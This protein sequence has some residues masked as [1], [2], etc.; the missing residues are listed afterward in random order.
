M[1]FFILFRR[2][3]KVSK[4]TIKQK[5]FADE[6]IISGNATEAAIKAGYSEKYVNT[7]ASK[8]LQNTT[9]KSYINEKLAELESHK[10]ATADEVLQVFSSILREEATEE[11]QQINPLTGRIETLIQKPSIKDRIAA[12]KELMKRYPTAKEAERLE[13][14]IEKLKLQLMDDEEEATQQIGFTFN[15][16]EADAEC[17]DTN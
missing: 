6:Y 10:I 7:N 5:K 14:E 2:W 15:R 9:L 3:W 13:L 4:L 8:L 11:T 1:W 12:G 17:R 16:G